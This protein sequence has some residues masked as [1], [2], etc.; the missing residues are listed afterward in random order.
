M[1]LLIIILGEDK[2]S[3]TL[4]IPNNIPGPGAYSIKDKF[5]KSKTQSF[6]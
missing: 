1:Y 5:V 6:S 3:S 4:E 2:K